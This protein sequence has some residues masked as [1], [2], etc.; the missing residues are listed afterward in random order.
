[1]D[2]VLA[3]FPFIGQDIFNELDAQSLEE[4]RNVSKVWRKFLDNN[5]LFWK[6][7]IQKITQNQRI[8][9]RDWKMV[10]TKVSTDTLKKLAFAVEDFSTQNYDKYAYQFSPLHVLAN[11]GM[12][13]LYKKIVV[14]TRVQI[15][16]HKLLIYRA[17][18]SPESL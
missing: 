6:R 2:E 13:V 15:F 5:P 10:T 11:E 9:K 7:R 16:H 1:M 17:N 4:S 3:K 14:K 18:R 12:I 8:F